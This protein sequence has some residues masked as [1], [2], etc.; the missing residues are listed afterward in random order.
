MYYID[1]PT[2]R[3]DVIDYDLAT[4]T[5]EYRRPLIEIVKGVGFPDGMTVDVDGCLWVAFW[6]GWCV[7]RYDPEGDLMQ[8]VE[9]PVSRVTSC[10]FGGENFDQLF[11]TS[12]STGLSDAERVAQPLAGSVFRADV[13]TRGWPANYF[14]A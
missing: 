8:T 10:T 4:G 14:A 5:V 6:D 3:V 12:A 1:T 13:G 9:L 11:I 2:M 7:R